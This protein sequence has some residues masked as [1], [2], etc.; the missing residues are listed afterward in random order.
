MK[1][2]IPR[3]LT[4]TSV[5][6][7]T[8]GLHSWNGHVKSLVIN[9]SPIGKDLWSSLRDSTELTTNPFDSNRLDVGISR[10]L[11]Y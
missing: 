10:A 3:A 6:I 7:T 1:T 8:G 11:P 2:A 9:D 4:A 5:G